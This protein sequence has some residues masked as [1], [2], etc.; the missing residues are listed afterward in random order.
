M[1][2]FLHLPFSPSPNLELAALASIK[3]SLYNTCSINEENINSLVAW[4]ALSLYTSTCG[5]ESGV[6]SWKLSCQ[7]DSSSHNN[8]FPSDKM[9]LGLFVFCLLSYLPQ[10][11]LGNISRFQ[12]VAMSHA[13]CILSGLSPIAYELSWACWPMAHWFKCKS[14]G[15]QADV[16]SLWTYQASLRITSSSST[17]LCYVTLPRH[18]FT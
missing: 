11:H 4:E 2:V 3:C 17:S 1:H 9:F 13:N 14:K 5:Q 12:L 15:G 7:Q 18:P 8:Y 10:L 6:C 16:F